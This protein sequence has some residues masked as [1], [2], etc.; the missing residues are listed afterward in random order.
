MLRGYNADD[1]ADEATRA[2]LLRALE[3]PDAA[4]R[5]LALDNLMRATN[6]GD[7]LGYDPDRPSPRGL[8]AWRE[9]LAP[10][11][12]ARD[13]RPAAPRTKDDDS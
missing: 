12:R 4:V 11:A 5:E 10:P 1:L 7:S 13:A 6:R 8:Q 2:T 9:L 3:H